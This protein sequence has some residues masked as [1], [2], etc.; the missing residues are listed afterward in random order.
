MH[1]LRIDS[2][3]FGFLHGWLGISEGKLEHRCNAR[4]AQ[5]NC[6]E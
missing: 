6:P 2:P 5:C 3:V 4:I 1:T